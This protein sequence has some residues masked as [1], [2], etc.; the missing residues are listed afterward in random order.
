[1]GL[2][3]DALDLK[4]GTLDVSRVYAG[5]TLVWAREVLDENELSL[6]PPFVG[7][8]GNWHR[9]ADDLS[10]N[11]YF[12][13]NSPPSEGDCIGFDVLLDEGTWLVE[14]LHLNQPGGAIATISVDGVDVGTVDTWVASGHPR[15]NKSY[16]SFTVDGRGVKRIVI[17]AATRSSSS[18]HHSLLLQTLRIGRFGPSADR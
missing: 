10:S 7:T 5:S 17:T 2:L 18:P 15:N 1:M 13:Y 6:T 11:G 4:L 16:V 8:V 9:K 14:L 3:N 12:T